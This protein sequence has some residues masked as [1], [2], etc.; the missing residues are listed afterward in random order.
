[1]RNY[2]NNLSGGSSIAR[3]RV[4]IQTEAKL[5]LTLQYHAN[6]I[7]IGEKDS[8]LGLVILSNNNKTNQELYNVL[9]NFN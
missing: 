3:N 4:R 1:M 8:L 6:Y 2:V 7:E 9:K 5:L